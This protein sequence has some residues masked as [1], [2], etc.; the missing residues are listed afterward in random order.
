MLRSSTMSRSSFRSR[1]GSGGNTLHAGRQNYATGA[2]Q[3]L[4]YNPATGATYV[5]RSSFVPLV[6]PIPEEWVHDAWI[7]LLIA[8]QSRVAL[9]PE[10]LIS[11]RIHSG[12]QIGVR[13]LRPSDDLL[14]NKWSALEERLAAL[15]VDP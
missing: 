1:C 8:T 7:A 5:F 13:Q 12:Q 10:M 3:L 9:V 11:Y 4:K 15:P 14:V 6:T 2:A